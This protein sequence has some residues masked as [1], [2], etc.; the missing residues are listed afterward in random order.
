MS[1]N[2]KAYIFLL[3]FLIFLFE[4]YPYPWVYST[5]YLNILFRKNQALRVLRTFKRAFR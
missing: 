1:D 5:A 3:G 4:F 2:L